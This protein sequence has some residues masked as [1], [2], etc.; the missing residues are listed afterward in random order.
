MFPVLRTLSG[1]EK[2]VSTSL[3]DFIELNRELSESQAA[4]RLRW[5]RL[6]GSIRALEVM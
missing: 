3:L 2:I 1:P 4:D 6:E 5:V